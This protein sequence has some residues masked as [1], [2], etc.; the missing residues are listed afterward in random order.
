MKKLLL[1]FSTLLVLTACGGNDESPVAE[2][3]NQTAELETPYVTIDIDEVMD[4]ID[5]GYTVVDVR[6]IDEFNSGHIPNAVNA[7]LS[8]LENDRFTPLE[9]NE[10]YI[11]ICQ[12]GNRS[13]TASNILSE[14][15]Y[16]IV[17]VSEG[18]STWTGE[19]EE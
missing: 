5:D 19:I 8:G 6:E 15:G 12:S 9:T 10:K 7:P 14:A 18:M 16:D 1:M 11:I 13:I 17:N 2:E 3:T 4:Y